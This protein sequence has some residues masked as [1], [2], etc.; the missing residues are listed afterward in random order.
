VK[1]IKDIND[2]FNEIA[3]KGDIDKAIILMEKKESFYEI[4]FMDLTNNKILY[5]FIYE[6]EDDD[7]AD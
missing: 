7:D 2:F 6:E 3:E 5:T 1:V 4:S